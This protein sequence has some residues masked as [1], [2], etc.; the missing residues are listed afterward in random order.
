MAFFENFDR[1]FGTLGIGIAKIRLQI[2]TRHPQNG[3]YANF[4]KFSY[5]ISVK[6]N[7]LGCVFWVTLFTGALKFRDDIFLQ[8]KEKA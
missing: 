1:D 4:G 5:I 3:L 2:R 6:N 8:K 7:R